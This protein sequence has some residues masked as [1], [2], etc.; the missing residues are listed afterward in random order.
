MSEPDP[1]PGR[2]AGRGG[3][4]FGALGVL[5]FSFT[6]PATRVAVADLDATVV[7]LGRAVVAACLAVAWLAWDGARR[8]SS[9]EWPRLALVAGGVVVGFPLFSAL[10]LRDVPAAHAAVVIGTLPAATA[11]MAVWRAHER[12]SL[13]FW[14]S[15]AAGLAGVIVFAAAQGTGRPQLADLYAL[16]A[17]ALGALGYAEGGALARTMGGARVISWALI[18]AAPILAPVVGLAALRSGLAA[19]PSAWL[20][21]AYVAIVSAFLGFFAW[22][23]GLA[24]GGVA[25]I[26]QIQ[27][28]Q[29][30]LTLLW[31]WLLLSEDVGITTVA[32]ALFI[33][34][35]VA[36]TQRARVALA[37]APGR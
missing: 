20:G 18:L 31:S 28:A 4:G 15:S 6:L 5:A 35:C 37:G 3:F 19:P 24:A 8:P 30:L 29:P 12:P 7:G 32:A 1:A 23:R 26:G 25:R 11:V 10:A 36:L 22:Y 14:A 33:L 13:A 27:L 21:F 16:A 34:G 17:V 2:A 9:S